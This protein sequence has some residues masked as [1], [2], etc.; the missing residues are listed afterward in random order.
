MT[1]Y[2]ADGYARIKG[3][4]ALVTTFG[5]G[6][7]SASNAIAGAYAE[8]V[9]IVNIVGAP[10]K[11]AQATGKVM[12]HTLGNGDYGA[13]K[14]MSD[15]ITCF[16]TDLGHTDDNARAIDQAIRECVVQSRPVCIYI[17]MDFLSEKV[18]SGSLQEPIDLELPYDMEKGACVVEM[19][20]KELSAAKK[21][22]ILVDHGAIRHKVSNYGTSEKFGY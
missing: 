4:S 13:F 5:V 14:R 12:H 10:P 18:D 20:L 1:G 11:N 19:V 15:Q 21:P 3:V 6:E 2:A 7:L 8:H 16:V 9:P 17:P 22:A